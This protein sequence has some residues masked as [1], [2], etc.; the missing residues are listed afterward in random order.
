MQML[1]QTGQM[2]CFISSSSENGFSRK[3]KPH[4]IQVYQRSPAFLPTR[5]VHPVSSSKQ[6]KTAVTLD[7]STITAVFTN[8]FCP[9]SLVLLHRQLGNL[10]YKKQETVS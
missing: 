4:F 2:T 5:F 1:P 6:D 7:S 8:A 9:I 10:K 3:I